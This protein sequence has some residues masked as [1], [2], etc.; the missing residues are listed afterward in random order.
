MGNLP[1]H[2]GE[3]F[4]LNA[5]GDG[6]ASMT[7]EANHGSRLKGVAFVAVLLL[8]WPTLAQPVPTQPV[9]DRAPQ[10]PATNL[11]R[12]EEDWQFLKDSSQREDFWDPL[13]YRP[14]GRNGW[15]M[16]V[17]G[18]IRPLFE[19][20]HNYNWGAGPQDKNGY[21]LQRFM[22]S[23]DVH[24][25]NRTRV[26]VELRS[27]D[28]FGRNGGPRPSQ[29]KDTVDVSQ[30]FIGVS[31]I[32]GGPTSKLEFKLGRQELNY[33]EGSLLAIRE[34]NV[35]RTF[36][37][38]KAIVRP[39]N[40]RI[41]LLAFRPA[42]NKPGAFDDGIDSS[43]AIWGVWAV[44]PIAVQSFWRQADFY[45][46]GLDRKQATFE[47]G[48]ARELRHTVGVLLHAQQHA[49]AMFTQ[50]DLQLGSFGPG[51]IR[52]WKYAQSLS[53]S[54]R[55]GPLR[56]VVT[57]LGAISSGDTGAASPVLQTFNPLF[58][59]GLYYGY[60]D[61]T[62]SPNAMVLHP[63]LGLSILPTV[64]ILVSHF[65]F[66]RTS[67]ADAIYSQPG[68]LLR[69]GNEGQSRYVGSLQDLAIRWRADRHT[70]VEALATYYEAGAFLRAGSLPGKDLF[71]VSLKMNYRF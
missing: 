48:T 50:A 20:Y 47:Q 13:K 57:L 67:A 58:P 43:Q 69:A 39:R 59:R 10:R 66:W 70:T 5:T 30:A 65:S 29:D 27:G 1:D 64:S 18:E 25:G 49:F 19:I 52:A 2:S 42:L 41:D 17:A 14:L 54:L 11:D 35:R 34:L 37:G 23:T 32:P 15:Y 63:Q 24:L 61:S 53:W 7:R 36:D 16:T 55:D 45:Y 6:G 22:G 31:V 3:T 4:D 51:S 28:V 8:A 44:R 38:V 71:Y 33:G 12:S 46:L 9:I 56:P 26:F 40:W 60:I 62:G 68:F 21:Y